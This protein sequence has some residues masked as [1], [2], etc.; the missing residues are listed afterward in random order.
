ITGTTWDAT[1][2]VTSNAPQ[3]IIGAGSDVFISKLNAAGNSLLYSTFLG[4]SGVDSATGIAVHSSGSVAISGTTSSADFPVTAGA[5]QTSLPGTQSA[6]AARLNADGSAFSF[7]TY[8]GGRKMDSGFGVAVD[9]PAGNVYVVGQTYSDNF[10]SVN[11]LQPAKKGTSSVVQKSV[12][13]GQTWIGTDSGIK[14]INA[15]AIRV[16][17]VDP[18]IVLVGTPSIV[19][20]S[21]DGGNTWVPVLHFVDS[22]APFLVASPVDPNVFYA[23]SCGLREVWKTIDAGQ[24]W[25]SV[26]TSTDYSWVRSVAAHPGNL[27]ILYAAT[28]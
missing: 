9:E 20:R 23:F 10:P 21:T 19:G 13:G 27:N 6:F 28:A 4:G 25:L 24:H 14:D 15:Y 8:L 12:D 17:A 2:P 16:H 5:I 3:K 7:V 22:C 18:S 11:A 1:F 26:S